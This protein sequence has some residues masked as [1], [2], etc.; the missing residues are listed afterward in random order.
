M[1]RIIDTAI[2]IVN[3]NGKKFL[4]TCLGS[5]KNQTYQDF[6]IILVD[7]GSD[8]GSINFMEERYPEVKLKKLSKNTGFAYANNVGIKEALNDER[9][10]FII[11][12]NNDTKVDQDY[13]K[14]LIQAA[15]KNPQAGSFQPKVINFF[16][17][18]IIDG[19]GILIYKDCSAINRGQKEEDVGQYEEKEEIFGSSASAALYTKDALE[20]IKFSNGDYFDNDY[21]AYYEDVD[22]AWRMRLAGFNSFYI[23]QAKVFHVH[24]ATGKSYS[25]FKA[26]HI[27]R[28]QYYNI[29]KNFPGIFFWEAL[30]FMPIRYC[31]LISSVFRKK[32]PAANLNKNTKKEKGESIFLIVLRSWKDV[33]INLLSLIKKRKFIQEAKQVSNGEVKKWFKIY[34]ADIK[35]IIYQ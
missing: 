18:N 30:F 21:F 20:K 28:N 26:F 22:L 5:L 31:L 27:H 10:K 15:K 9:I 13:L 6:K 24:S 14:F 29:I 12:L 11:T 19:V 35:K 3:W 2:V 8:D 23:P 16:D 33:I 32:G 17:K 4:E 25:S 7:N 34:K 1:K